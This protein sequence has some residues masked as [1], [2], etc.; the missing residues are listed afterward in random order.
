MG[1]NFPSREYGARS[2]IGTLTR[3]VPGASPYWAV[4]PAPD[5][6]GTVAELPLPP[7]AVVSLALGSRGHGCRAGAAE[8]C[9]LR[10]RTRKMC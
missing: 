6:H 8:A 4:L 7:L 3:P 2:K 5:G 1:L 9:Q 10:R